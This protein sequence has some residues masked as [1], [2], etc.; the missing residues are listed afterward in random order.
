MKRREFLALST[1]VAAQSFSKARQG[2]G[3]LARR[4][5]RIKQQRGNL[6]S[7]VL[8][9]RADP[10]VPMS[11]HPHRQGCSTPRLFV[12]R[13]LKDGSGEGRRFLKV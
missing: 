3:R 12:P 4:A 13:T 11:A 9:S 10:T 8:A 2:C 1:G 6:Y 5:K 7:S